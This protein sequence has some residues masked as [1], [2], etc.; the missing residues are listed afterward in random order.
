[1]AKEFLRFAP[2]S[3]TSNIDDLPVILT[4]NLFAIKGVLDSVQ[5]GHI[6]VVYSPPTKPAQGDIRYA[7]GTTWNPGAGE[8]IYF[9]NSSG[10]W[11]KL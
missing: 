1:M 8:G 6:D 2:E 3:A 5:D 7:D 9:Y 11:V 10:A 4:N